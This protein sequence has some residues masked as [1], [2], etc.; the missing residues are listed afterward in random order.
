MI[1]VKSD[2]TVVTRT[3]PTTCYSGSSAPSGQTNMAWY[4]TSN[5]LV[6]LTSD[7]GST[8]TSGYSL[9]IAIATITSDVITSIDQI[10]NGFG[11]IGSTVFALPGVKGLIPNGRNA[12]GTLKNTEIVVSNV[13][14]KEVSGSFTREIIVTRDG[15]M[16]H[17][18]ITT[19][20]NASEISSIGWYYSIEDNILGVY[21]PSTQTWTQTNSYVIGGTVDFVDSKVTS[22]QP[23]LPFRAVDYI[24]MPTITY[25]E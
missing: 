13:G 20:R 2:R 3:T 4:D 18:P 10:F 11:Y 12:D 1:F 6:K 16:Q 21:T 15:Y 17:N 22:F 7:R 24:D 25:W 9:P 8:W 14:T 5:N 23:K 19:V